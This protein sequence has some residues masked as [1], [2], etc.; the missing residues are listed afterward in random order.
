MNYVKA[1]AGTIKGLVESSWEKKDGRLNI[2][3]TIPVNTTAEL[4]LP[5]S[6]P[7][8]VLENGVTAS[9]SDEVNLLKTDKQKIVVALMLIVF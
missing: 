6:N 9:A 8:A 2:T 4:H 7:A 1:S 5:T 3:I